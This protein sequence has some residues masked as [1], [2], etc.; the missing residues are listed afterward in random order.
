MMRVG[1]LLLGCDAAHA[2]GYLT[3]PRP[4]PPLWAESG[5]QGNTGVSATYRWA[6]PAFTLNGPMTH[7]GHP[8]RVDSY[9]CHDLRR[10][11]RRPT[12]LQAILWTWRGPS[13]RHP[14]ELYATQGSNPRLADTTHLCYSHV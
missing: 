11:R 2:H 9:N 13:K 8:Y 6:E 4:R 14:G 10:R 5:M 3:M 1:L 12:S 7:N